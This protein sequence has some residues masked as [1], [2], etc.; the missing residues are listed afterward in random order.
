MPGGHRQE[1]GGWNRVILQVSDLPARID[2]LRKAG[3]H[4]RNE[5]E[6]GPGG[7]QVQI[8]DPDGN[9][10]ELFEPA[11]YGGSHDVVRSLGNTLG[12]HTWDELIYSEDGILVCNRLEFRQRCS[13]V[14]WEVP[15]AARGDAYVLADDGCPLFRRH[16]NKV[17]AAPSS[18]PDDGV[19][20]R[21]FN[22]LHPLGI[23]SE[24]RHEVF[25][26]FYTGDYHRRGPSPAGYTAASFKRGLETGR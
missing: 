5:M 11:Q 23:R 2:A 6:T 24:H 10:I 13:K 7:R 16:R 25:L 12:N 4:F 22:V 18:V 8:E 1:P 3:L 15:A 21:R 9:P 17:D 14:E 19:A 20:M 26:T